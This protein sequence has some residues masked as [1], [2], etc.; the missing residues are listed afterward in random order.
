MRFLFATT[1]ALLIACSFAGAASAA[2]RAS[3]P[4]STSLQPIPQ[5]VHADVSENVQRTENDQG[6]ASA[7]AQGESAPASESPQSA[8][9]GFSLTE[10]V[11]GI[12]IVLLAL[13][14]IFSLVR[15]EEN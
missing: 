11:A 13:A 7:P 2:M 12:A 9:S 15:Q 8:P 4:D 1:L 5:Q 3:F 10:I 14:A 6:K